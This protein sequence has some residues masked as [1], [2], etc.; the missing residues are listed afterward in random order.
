LI[1]VVLG[2]VVGSQDPAAGY[3]PGKS[4]NY[5]APLSE[6]GDRV[7]ASN[8]RV[9]DERSRIYD[10]GV[11]L[12]RRAASLAQESFDHFRG[13]N[14]TISDQ[15]QGVLFKS[16]AFASSARL[17]L[18]LAETRSDYFRG[19]YLRT[20]LFRA[21]T[22]LTESFG[23][24]EQEMRKGGVQ[25]FSLSECRT[26]LTR[27]EREFAAWPDADNFAYLDQK[28]VKARDASVYLIERRGIG[29][30]VRRPFQNLESLFRYNYDRKRGKDPWAYLVEISEETLDRMRAGP[31]VRLNFEGAMII[32]QGDRKNRGVYL[33]RD[34]KKHGLTR[35]E[36]VSRFG[37]WGKVYEV[38]REV[39]DSYENGDPI[40]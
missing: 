31:P 40:E 12:E 22:Y 38:P 28:Y 34:G 30:Y 20:N 29:N 2:A 3:G 25:P 18:K 4:F 39:I 5:D 10:L 33:I 17:F 1:L 13:W 37:G 24:L 23:E 19:D 16:G 7:T 6:N 9:A 21:F 36:L 26:L 15:E 35:P 11:E 14:G 27:M 32:E 8:P